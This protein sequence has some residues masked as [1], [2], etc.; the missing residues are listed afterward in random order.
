MVCLR[1]DY[2]I[3]DIKVKVPHP[4]VLNMAHRVWS[5]GIMGERDDELTDLRDGKR[6]GW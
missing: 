2:T 1:S 4:A 5:G 6:V 3:L